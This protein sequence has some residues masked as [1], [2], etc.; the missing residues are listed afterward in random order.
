MPLCILHPIGIHCHGAG[1]TIGLYDKQNPSS[2]AIGCLKH[3]LCPEFNV[4]SPVEEWDNQRSTFIWKRWFIST[5]T[6]SALSDDD[7]HKLILIG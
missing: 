2:G 4:A 5:K 7:W 1:P 6:A 3:R